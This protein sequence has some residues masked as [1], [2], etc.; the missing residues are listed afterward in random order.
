[1]ARRRIA[2]EPTSRLAI[3]PSLRIFSFTATVSPVIVRSTSWNRC[4]QLPP[5][6]RAVV[7][8]IRDRAGV[9]GL[10]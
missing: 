8:T 4:R 6:R 10:S 1:V 2:D 3:W 5:W 7:R 9:R